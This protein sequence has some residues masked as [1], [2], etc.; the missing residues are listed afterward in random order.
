MLKISKLRVE[1]LQNPL[2]I[3]VTKPRLS[4]IIEN[5]DGANLIRNITQESYQ[6][7]VSSNA[8]LLKDGQPDKWDSGKIQSSQS[9]NIQYQGKP[10]ESHQK[11]YWAVNIWDNKGNKYSSQNSENFFSTGPINDLD[12]KG[13]WIGV[14]TTSKDKIKV[15]DEAKNKVV[16]I[17]KSTPSQYLRKEFSVDGSKLSKIKSV[18]LYSTALGDYICY[19][20]GERIGKDYFSPEWTNYHKRALFQTYDLQKS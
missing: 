4:W 13:K 16:E 7:M 11:Y 6:I 10:F 18:Y 17:I 2:G 3:T 20:N 14:E 8:Q 19:I 5:E 9:N 12:W 15:K 1:Y